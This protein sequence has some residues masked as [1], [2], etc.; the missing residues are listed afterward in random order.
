MVVTIAERKARKVEHLSSAS[1]EVMSDLRAYASAHGGRFL[2]FG[3]TARQELRFDSDFD[4]VVD[5]PPQFER[6]ARDYAE[7]VCLDHRVHPDIHLI[8]EVSDA[9]MT[10]VQRDAVVLP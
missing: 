3:S 5:F 1:R 9:L 10:R 2:V 6:S 8:A 4:V 7:G